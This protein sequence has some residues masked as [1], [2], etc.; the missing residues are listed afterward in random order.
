MVAQI[1][2]CRN[3]WG[4]GLGKKSSAGNVKEEARKNKTP[5]P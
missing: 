4:L 1:F 3:D 2:D 5:E